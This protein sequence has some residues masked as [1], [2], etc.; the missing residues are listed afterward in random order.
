MARQGELAGAEPGAR[1]TVDATIPRTEIAVA[2]HPV[3]K[4]AD[5][6]QQAWT[7]RRLRQGR[8]GPD[9]LP[10]REKQRHEAIELG[11]QRVLAAGREIELVAMRNLAGRRFSATSRYHDNVP[12]IAASSL[13]LKPAKSLME[14][15]LRP[16][17][18]KHV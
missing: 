8:P 3:G 13:I 14:R 1:H 18:I 17:K 16:A 12:R 10:A 4:L 6:L 5:K 7:V 9:R 11:P 15:L 2:K